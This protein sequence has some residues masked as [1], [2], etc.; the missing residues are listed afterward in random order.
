M[1]LDVNGVVRDVDASPEMPLLW[2]LRDLLGLTGTKYGCGM[3]QCG[4]CTVHLDGKPT[5]SCV[6]PVSS[7]GTRKVTTIE[8][9]S[10]DGSHAVQQAW[11]QAD[12]V[13]CGYCQS[14][15]IMTAVALLEQ[16]PDPSDADID[17]AL[18][19]NVCRCGTY[20]RVREA[21]I[22]ASRLKRGGK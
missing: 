22:L 21:V 3:A 9:L 4:A 15:Q 8:G 17:A 7:V 18:S 14:G 11:A 5:R 1:K 10:P 13:Q 19:G 16:K 2:V 6:L 20:V 12:V